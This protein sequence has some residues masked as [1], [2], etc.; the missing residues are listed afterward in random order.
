[1]N[2]VLKQLG[3]KCIFSN[4]YRPQDNS[5]I[6]NVHNFFKWM[7]AKF[8]SSADTEWGKILPFACSCFNTTPRADDLESPFFPHSR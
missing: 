6:E 4:P 7:L 3:I 2:T 8:L 5:C 1:M